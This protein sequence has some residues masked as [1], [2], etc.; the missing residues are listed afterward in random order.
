M[1]ISLLVATVSFALCGA[2]HAAGTFT[3][4]QTSGVQ[5]GKISSNGK[6]AAGLL[7]GN[8]A[9]RWT[10]ST[11][12]EEVID[13]MN[14][15]NGVNNLGSISGSTAIDGGSDN[16]GADM[17][18][19]SALGM[20]PTNLSGQLNAN[21]Q[22]WD[23][24]DNGTVVGG[25]YDNLFE[26]FNAFVWTAGGGMILLPVQ[27][28]TYFSRADSISA[29][30]TIISGY[31]DTDLDRNA[32][33]WKN[34]VEIELTDADG[35][36]LD[37]TNSAVSSN[38]KFVIGS[39]YTDAHGISGA[40]RYNVETGVVDVLE[41]LPNGFGISDD[42]KTAVGNNDFFTTPPRAAVIWHEGKG[43]AELLTDYLAAQGVAVPEELPAD[44]VGGFAG[45]SGD[46]S[47]MTGWTSNDNGNVSYVIH[48]PRPAVP[49]APSVP[50]PVDAK[51]ALILLGMLAIGVAALQLKKKSV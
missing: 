38:G 46:G 51:W 45:I 37:G 4:L 14:F 27:R 18:A 16:G 7:D 8:G 44:L 40:W 42:G 5:L 15:T 43:P 47:T 3:L 22:G 17:G 26:S 28:P 13:G 1:R 23:I 32:V 49:A 36:I 9:L 34:R 35:Y 2:A 33:I 25:S 11:A 20:G 39:N 12:S 48:I 10:T 29:D 6:Y 30:G 31:N 24:A 19:Y 41:G 21:A 50:V